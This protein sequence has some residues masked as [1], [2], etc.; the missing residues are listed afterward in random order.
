M[1]NCILSLFNK[2]LLFLLL[3]HPLTHTHR[4]RQTTCWS[5]AAHT[6]TTIYCDNSHNKNRAKW[7]LYNRL[8]N[9]A[10]FFSKTVIF[11]QIQLNSDE[12]KQVAYIMSSYRCT[13]TCLI[14]P[15]V[16]Y[17]TCSAVHIHASTRQAFCS[18]RDAWLALCS[19]SQSRH[20]FHNGGLTRHGSFTSL[21]VC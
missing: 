8:I 15:P 18:A 20:W 19:V 6:K 10:S 17:F 21:L 16:F 3:L 2:R 12:F 1:F 14:M 13:G 7:C 4:L 5:T 9:A 11:T